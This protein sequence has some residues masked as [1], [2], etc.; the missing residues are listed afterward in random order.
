MNVIINSTTKRVL[1]AGNCFMDFDLETEESI[2]SSFLFNPSIQDTI[3]KYENEEFVIDTLSV[4]KEEKIEAIKSKTEVEENKG[5]P[6][7]NYRFSVSPSAKSNWLAI[8]VA[9]AGLEYPFSAPTGFGAIYNFLDTNDIT[10]FFGTS[11]VFLKYWEESNEVLV[12][13]VNACTTVEE[14]DAII[15]NRSYPPIAP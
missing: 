11:I 10:A 14:V 15:D 1:R 12:I 4:K 6:Y 2:V 13:A 9:S 5:V 3:W 7:N 8:V